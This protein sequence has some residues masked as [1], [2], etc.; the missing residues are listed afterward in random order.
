[1][2]PPV[3]VKFFDLPPVQRQEVLRYAG[4]RAETPELTRLLS[5]VLAETQGLF[6]GRVCYREFPLTDAGAGLDLAFVKTSSRSLRQA[7]LG[8]DRIVVFAATVGIGL[9]RLIRRYGS[10][11]PAKALLLQALG[12]E[13]IEALCDSF[14]SEITQQAAAT[15]TCVTD[16]FS[17]GYGD[18]PLD[19][20]RDI[21]RVLDCQKTIGLTLNE[22]LLMSPSKSVTAIM[23]LGPNCEPHKTT[24]C[25]HCSKTDCIHRRSL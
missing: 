14:C 15:G 25:S 16:R 1:M 21:F 23:G 11:S 13:R 24:G 2:I 22:S 20:Q 4:T 18:L 17:P 3:S 8:C 10:V 9:D 12:A 19:L 5:E 7:L 6:S